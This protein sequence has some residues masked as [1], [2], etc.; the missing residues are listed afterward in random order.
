MWTAA[1]SAGQWLVEQ[2]RTAGDRTAA[3]RLEYYSIVYRERWGFEDV[4][5]L[6]AA[7]RDAGSF[8]YRARREDGVVV[9][10]GLTRFAT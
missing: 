6:D 8:G 2:G 1:I 3:P 5:A 7:P 10:T 4:L 9:A